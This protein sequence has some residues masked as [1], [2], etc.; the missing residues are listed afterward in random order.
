MGDWTVLNRFQPTQDNDEW[1][2]H[3]GAH[4][5]DGGCDVGELCHR[6]VEEHQVSTKTQAPEFEI[7][8]SYFTAPPPGAIYQLTIPGAE[9]GWKY[10]M[11]WKQD[12]RGR[13]LTRYGFDT[14][15]DAAAAAEYAAKEIAK[16]MIPVV[17]YTYTPEI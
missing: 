2:I 15:E 16:V 10:N 6:I 14:R 7:T 11:T 3:R 1:F 9:T 5:G 4:T 8:T 12:G 13:S 17:T